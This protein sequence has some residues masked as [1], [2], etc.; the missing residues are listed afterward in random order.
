M[1]NQIKILYLDFGNTIATPI[2]DEDH[3]ENGIKEILTK[4]GIIGTELDRRIE[5]FR[6]WRNLS[7][8]TGEMVEIHREEFLRDVFGN[9]PKQIKYF[10]QY[11]CDVFRV[12]DNL[13]DL[14]K[15]ARS[16]GVECNIITDGPTMELI[17]GVF[18]RKLIEWNLFGYLS[19]IYSPAGAIRPNGFR[20]YSYKGKKKRDGTLYDL[21]V[22][23]LKSRKPPVRPEE[24]I[25]VGDNRVSDIE[26]SMAKGFRA[27]QYVG[28]I[29]DDAESEVPRISD[30]WDLMAYV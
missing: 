20:D 10:H 11:E 9:D 8:S 14:L 29:K 13:E 26:K 3:R 1:G 12:A 16:R 2:G 18:V 30:F 15:H 7:G 21:L 24:C 6:R 27:F 25:V 4:N 5:N 17:E 22:K 28:F 23:E 19:T